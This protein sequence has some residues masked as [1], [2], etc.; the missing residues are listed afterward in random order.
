MT[1]YALFRGD[2][3]VAHNM[4]GDDRAGR[5]H[6]VGQEGD[7]LVYLGIKHIGTYLWNAPVNDDD[8]YWIQFSDPD[9]KRYRVLS[10]IQ[11]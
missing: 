11:T 2:K 7:V 4:G 6:D 8:N 3:L 10:L 1:G 9:S 5:L